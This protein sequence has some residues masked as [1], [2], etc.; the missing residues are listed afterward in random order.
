MPD[1]LTITAG[2]LSLV[3]ALILA[4]NRYGSDLW[5][6]PL[7]EIVPA[8]LRTTIE[9]ELADAAAEDKFGTPEAEP[10][11]NED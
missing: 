2:I 3:T 7:K 4:F 6:K 11:G 9:K 5:D 10:P 1:P 8:K